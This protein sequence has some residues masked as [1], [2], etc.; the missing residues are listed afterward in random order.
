MVVEYVQLKERKVFNKR[1]ACCLLFCMVPFLCSFSG[2]QESKKVSAT[3]NQ[4]KFEKWESS[5]KGHAVRKNWSQFGSLVTK[6]SKAGFGSGKIKKLAAEI[7]H[8]ILT[9]AVKASE[10]MKKLSLNLGISF[11]ELLELNL[12][13]KTK[14]AQQISKNGNYLGRKSTG[15][16]RS[17]EYNPTTNLAFIH[18]QTHGI[19]QV[20]EG[21]K[22]VVTK[23]ILYHPSRP[24]IV[25]HCSTKIPMPKEIAALKKLQ[26]LPGI[27]ETK[28]F[29]KRKDSKGEAVY[30]ILCQYYRE[31]DLRTFLLNRKI[32]LSLN[33]K[34]K[35]ASDILTG[36]ESMHKNGFVHRDLNIRNYLVDVKPK[37]KNQKTE[38]K[39]VIA[40]LGRTIPINKVKGEPVQWN[41]YYVA[42]EG[43]FHEKLEGKDY[44][45]SDIYAVGCA[46]YNLLTG[47]RAP[48]VNKEWIKGSKG[49]AKHRY[50]EYIRTLR[51]FQ[52][53]IT[54]KNRHKRGAEARFK[55]LILSMCDPVPKRRGN[56]SKLR[57]TLENIIRDAKK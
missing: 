41:P 45:Y 27:V 37:G 17:V 21:R 24:E 19:S 36:L 47:K 49:S 39:A 34:M 48:W 11:A 30:G 2:A 28:A 22:K 52:R 32:R 15:L 9:T 50:A 38:I 20:G 29:T 6:A 44:T 25:A 12:F 16:P 1:T 10:E 23:S 4:E 51:A 53:R 18:L 3:K 43:L 26:G 8:P 56:V 7:N 57:A 40:D 54:V 35:I 33:R 5:L 46:F 55:R 31:G 14:M 13:I 42:P